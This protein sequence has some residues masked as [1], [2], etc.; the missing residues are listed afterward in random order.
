MAAETEIVAGL[1]IA[2]RLL[3]AERRAREAELQCE[4]GNAI[5]E[6]RELADGYALRFAGEARWLVLLA[7]FIGFERECCPFLRFELHAEQQLGSF[8][9]RLRG[10]AGAKEFI[11]E[12][13]GPPAT[14][15]AG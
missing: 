10:P 5:Q 2:C 1:P 8:W 4:I 3:P 13:I 7:D 15:S 11:A 14:S 9:L 12:L 6:I